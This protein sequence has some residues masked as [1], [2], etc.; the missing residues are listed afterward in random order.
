M[1]NSFYYFFSAT[2]QVL[3]AILAL[4]GV[5]VVFKIQTIKNQLIGIG[6]SIADEVQS[7]IGWNTGNLFLTSKM[8]A[9]AYITA[10][11][12]AIHMQDIKELQY[13]INEIENDN[14]GVYQEKYNKLYDFLKSLIKSTIYWSIFTAI[15]IIFCLTIIPLKNIVLSYNYC[16]YSSYSLVIVCLIFCFYKLISILK[17]SL[18]G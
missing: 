2:S 4:F 10:L 14:Y 5:F 9:E 17:R 16:L 6:Q 18:I 15:I 3:A 13:I 8:R 1:N 11:K 12:M 7:H